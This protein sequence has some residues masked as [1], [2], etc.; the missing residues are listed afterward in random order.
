M[1]KINWKLDKNYTESIFDNISI[2]EKTNIKKV[3]GFIHKN[4]GINYEK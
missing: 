1:S 4:L 2:K 3:K